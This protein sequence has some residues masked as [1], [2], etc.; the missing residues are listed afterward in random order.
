MGGWCRPPSSGRVG[1]PAHTPC[2]GRCECAGCP[3]SSQRWVIPHS[4]G[5]SIWMSLWWL[6]VSWRQWLGAEAV[7]HGGAVLSG[8]GPWCHGT[9]FGRV[10]PVPLLPCSP[11]LLS[12]TKPCVSLVYLFR[13]LFFPR[14]LLI[15]QLLFNWTDGCL[16]LYQDQF[17]ANAHSDNLGIPLMH[18]LTHTFLSCWLLLFWALCQGWAHQV[19]V[20]HQAISHRNIPWRS[21]VAMGQS[22]YA[23]IISMLLSYLRK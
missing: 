20:T 16:P 22:C 14:G 19:L 10:T 23:S 8:T 15:P 17:W 5:A 12:A 2:S 21:K 3:P 4:Q 13:P 6:E 1:H 11:L 9:T 7:A 18:T